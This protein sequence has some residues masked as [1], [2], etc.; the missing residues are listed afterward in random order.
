[1]LKVKRENEWKVLN[2]AL[3]LDLL[4]LY[5]KIFWMHIFCSTEHYTSPTY[6]CGAQKCNGQS[7]AF[8]LASSAEILLSRVITQ[9]VFLEDD[10]L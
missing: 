5:S 8:R 3:H 7:E 4:M 1:M 10:S 9:S 6:M 2:V